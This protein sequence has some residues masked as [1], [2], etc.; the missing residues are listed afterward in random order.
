MGFVLKHINSPMSPEYMKYLLEHDTVH[1]RFPG[2]VELSDN[3]L[4]INGLPVTLSATRDPTEIPWKDAGVEYVCES[5]GAFT[6][7]EGCM[8]HIDGGAKKVIISAPAKDADTPTIVVGVN[9]DDYETSMKVVSC[10]S[11]TTNGLAPIVKVINEKFGIKQG[12]MTT[13]HAATASQMVVDSSMK[14]KDW[15]AGRAA[16]ANI[17]PSSTGA[18]KA[19]AKV[20]PVMKGKLT[21]MAFR[22]PTVD[23][24]VVDLTCELE[25]PTTYDD[26]KAEVKRASM[27]EGKGVVGYTEDQVVSSD[28]V[29]ETCSTVFDAEA[30]IMLTPTFVKLVSW[31]DNEWGYSTRLVDLVGVM[32]VKDGIK[33]KEEGTVY[34]TARVQVGAPEAGASLKKLKVGEVDVA[35]KRVFIRVDFN[36]PQD[37]SDPSIITNTQRIDAALPTIKDVLAKG[38]KSVVLASHLGRPDGRVQEKFSMAPVA[39]VLEKKLGKS[40]TLLNG[41]SGPEVEAT[42]A[43]PAPGSVILLENLRFNVEE[44]GKGKDEEG[45]KVKA[46]ADKVTAFRASIRKLADIYVNDAFGTAHRAHISMVGEGFETKA[47]GGLMASEL[48]AFAKVLDNPAK[49]VL[50][51]LG[52]AKVSDKI[53]LIFNMLDKVDKLIIGGG[54][55]YTFLK[56]NDGMSIGSSLY[57]EEGAKVVPDIM[58]KA[59]EKGVDI[60]L[61]VD[62]TISSKFGEDGEV[63]DVTK[64]QG[65][66][67]GFMGLD[68]GPKSNVLN[69]EA[70]DASKTIIWNGPMGVFEMAK[71]EAGTKALMEAVVGATEKGA[72][73]VIGGGD[74][75]TACKKYKTMEKVTHCSTGG[76]ASMELL[77][78]K[79]LPGVAALSDAR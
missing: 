72:V 61:P 6:T 71:F 9:T 40:V 48:D 63:K 22:M 70:V 39:K 30:G 26:I 36:V 46:D 10:A 15:R 37:K 47:T 3:G 25:K 23:V 32:A 58:A 57:D 62:F 34:C 28:F 69:K 13:V 55:A 14:G 1:G 52:G 56:I 44:E 17:I 41:A 60:I 43:D 8:K 76:G 51:I 20:Y 75:A 38:A 64:E 29:G 50:A 65:I 18:A 68:C 19:V 12:L 16:S 7:T 33:V 4:L 73:S 66:P 79:V 67:E 74:T 49:P 11:C 35:G 77:E 59:K 21:G 54:V 5:A 2:K 27:E 31:Y 53:Q 45:N 78:G 24:S 42:C